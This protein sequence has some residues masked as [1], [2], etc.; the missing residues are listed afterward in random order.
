MGEHEAHA[1][2]LDRVNV[3]G[4]ISLR[5]DPLLMLTKTSGITNWS[6]AHERAGIDD[7]HAFAGVNACEIS[8]SAGEADIC[9]AW[10]APTALSGPA[11]AE[12]AAPRGGAHLTRPRTRH[13]LIYC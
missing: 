12:L 13:L 6:D 10:D 11:A 8:A 4:C 7:T 9:V 2:R 3:A 5:A 1:P